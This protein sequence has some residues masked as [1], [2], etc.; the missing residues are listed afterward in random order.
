MKQSPIILLLLMI[1]LSVFFVGQRAFAEKASDAPY[2]IIPIGLDSGLLNGAETDDPVFSQIVHVEG[3]RWVRLHVADYDLGSESY[4]R[5]T[6]QQDG[7]QQRHDSR[8][9]QEWSNSSA[10][11]NGD[12]VIVEL[13]ASPGDKNVFVKIDSLFAGNELVVGQSDSTQ[14]PESLCGPDNRVA[15]NN[16]RHGRL[17]N[18]VSGPTCTVWLVS[19]GAVLTAGHCV[20]FDPDGPGPMLPDGNLDLDQFSIVEFNV[21]ASLADGTPVFSAPAHQYPVNLGSVVW[22]YEGENTVLGRDWAVLRV[23]RNADTRLLPH[24]GYGFERMV[25]ISPNPGDLI[26]ISGYG[27]DITP[28]GST[29]GANAQS[30]TNQTNT[31]PFVARIQNGADIYYRYQ[32]DTEGGNS[33]GPI[34]HTGSGFTVGI[35]TNGGCNPDGS[36]GNAGTA[37]Q[38]DALEAAI[39]SVWGPQTRYV[40]FLRFNP[41]VVETGM[42]FQPFDRV[43][44]A[45]AVVP[46]GG[47]VSIAAGIYPGPITIDRPVTLIAPVGPV[48]IGG[49]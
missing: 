43:A 13:F 12:T 8:S 29:G 34:I 1:T 4:I 40:D 7:S 26:R 47:I 39:Q 6:S 35:H 10:F 49:N 36:G 18:L 11:F 2:E 33:G 17:S 44:E 3:A 19:N 32:V 14:S 9:L 21:P 30:Q 46:N 16:Q 28:P 45:A 42:I 5:F 20:D 24:Q 22:D 25:D 37:F 23:N 15:S 31:G 38:V 41:V 27:V 48:T